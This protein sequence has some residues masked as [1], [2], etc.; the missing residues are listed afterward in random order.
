MYVSQHPFIR[1]QLISVRVSQSVS[2]FTTAALSSQS[3]LD[4]EVFHWNTFALIIKRE[5]IGVLVSQLLFVSQA[6]HVSQSVSHSVSQ[7]VGQSVLSICQS[8]N[9]SVSQAVNLSQSVSV[10]QSLCQSVSQ[11]TILYYQPPTRSHIWS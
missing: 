8:V 4:T 1:C 2:Q 6:V 7:S 11:F 9:H 10:S 3:Y 5:S